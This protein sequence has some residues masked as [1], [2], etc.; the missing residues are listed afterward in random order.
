[1][2]SGLPVVA[3]ANQGYKD[4]LRGKKAEDPSTRAKLDAGP[5]PHRI[6]DSGAGF[7]VKP[8][9]YRGLAKAIEILIEKPKLR[10]EMGEWGIKE[11]EKYSWEKIANRVL[12]FYKLCKKRRKKRNSLD[13]EDIIKETVS[14]EI[15]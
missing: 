9:D 14:K 7:L 12:N 4:F 2:A 13:L 8:K 3:F 15:K 10:K 6:E 1:M 5:V 11:A